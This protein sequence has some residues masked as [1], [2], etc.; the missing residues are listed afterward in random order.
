MDANG[1]PVA[2]PVS[3]A[4]AAAMTARSADPVLSSSSAGSYDVP[5]GGVRNSTVNNNRNYNVEVYAPNGL[6]PAQLEEY[7]ILQGA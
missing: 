1:N 3:P 7:L 2:P 5:A 6:S 4:A